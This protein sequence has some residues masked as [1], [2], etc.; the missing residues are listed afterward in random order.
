ML[1]AI[2]ITLI[3]LHLFQC[4]TKSQTKSETKTHI[5]GDVLLGKWEGRDDQGKIGAYLTIDKQKVIIQ[6]LGE[7]PATNQH[8]YELYET[9]SGLEIKI[10]GIEERFIVK[11]GQSGQMYLGLNDSDR[12][13]EAVPVLA[14]L[15]F[16]KVD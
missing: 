16:A 10:E 7:M 6:Y 1:K 15:T 4:G 14:M 9:N 12:W 3:C 8:Q 2:V 5:N 13:K 11:L